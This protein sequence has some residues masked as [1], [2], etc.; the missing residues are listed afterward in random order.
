M[1]KTLIATVI[2]AGFIAACKAPQKT[3]TTTPP[4]KVDCTN[5]NYSYAADIKSII[6][7]NC[8]KCHNSNNKAGYNFLTLESVKKGVQNGELL[9]T[10]KFLKGYPK[11]PKMAPQ[12]SQEL[13]DKI[14]CWI[15]N[16]M[17]E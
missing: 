12:L 7:S 11:M 6:E 2:L 4:L 14:E 3:A 9:G 15:N 5:K 8:S 17:K 16:G 10:I 13:I 1:K